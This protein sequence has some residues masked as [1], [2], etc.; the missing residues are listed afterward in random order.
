M[1]IEAQF[2]VVLSLSGILRAYHTNAVQGEKG[3]RAVDGG[4]PFEKAAR[5]R[6]DFV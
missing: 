4:R 6:S 2:V 5:A 3:A 1:I